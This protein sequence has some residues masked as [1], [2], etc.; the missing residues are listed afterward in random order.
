MSKYALTFCH[1]TVFRI[2]NI[3][4]TKINTWFIEP[5]SKYKWQQN[6]QEITDV[7][8]TKGIRKKHYVKLYAN[9]L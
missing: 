3:Q 5:L 1:G 4:K 6:I 9:K 8:K 7:E 2:W